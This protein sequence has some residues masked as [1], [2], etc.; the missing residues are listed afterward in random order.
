VRE[1]ERRGSVLFDEGLTIHLAKK[2]IV[3]IIHYGVEFYLLSG[4]ESPAHIT[5]LL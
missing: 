3:I 5:I 4:I 1:P 2:E